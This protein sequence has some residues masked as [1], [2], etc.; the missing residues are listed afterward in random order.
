MT[1]LTFAGVGVRHPGGAGVHGLDLTVA[2]GEIVALIGLNGAGKTTLM[3]LALGMLRP[4]SGVVRILGRPLG[5]LPRTEWAQVGQLV[6][7]PS[8]YPELTTRENLRIAA[9]LRGAAPSTAEAALDEWHL[10]ALAGRRFGRLSLGNRQ[11]VGLAAALQHHPRLV[12]LDEPSNALDPAA[13]L[14]LRDA[15]TRRARAG[16]AVLVSSH[17]LDEVARIAHRIVIMNAGRLIGDL[18]PVGADLEQAFFARVLADDETRART[19]G[20]VL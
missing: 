6:E 11:R 10:G 14:L 19:Q 15:L 5:E 9:R 13:V 18:D 12:V 16:A 1:S 20:E 8:A 2:P 7:V 4:A 17:H 3:R